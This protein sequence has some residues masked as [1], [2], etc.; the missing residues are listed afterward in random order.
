[1]IFNVWT[2][3][4]EVVNF[5]VLVYVLHRLLYRPLREAIDQRREA[6]AKAQADAEKARQEADRATSSS[7]SAQLAA[8]DQERQDVIRKAREQAEAER[9]AIDGRGR[10]RRA[11]RREEVEQQLEARADPGARDRSMPSSFNRR[12]RWRS[13]SC[14]E[15]RSSTPPAAAC[16][17]ARRGAGAD[18][19][20]RAPAACAASWKPTTPPL[21]KRPRN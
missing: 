7:S 20:R 3:L 10:A 15:A 12:W 16:R 8:I 11:K 21:S 5:L 19:G 1:M 13:V 4:F 14:S 2:F 18:P 9:K 17:A 6:N